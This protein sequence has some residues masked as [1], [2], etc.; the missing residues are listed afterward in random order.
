MSLIVSFLTQDPLQSHKLHEICVISVSLNQENSILP[1]IF[2]NV[3]NFLKT[4]G[5]LIVDYASF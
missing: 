5:Q 2:F 1:L 4:P 3:I